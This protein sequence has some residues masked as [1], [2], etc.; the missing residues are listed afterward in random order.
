M[1]YDPDRCEEAAKGG[2]IFSAWLIC[3]V[4]ILMIVLVSKLES[5]TANTTE[6]GTVPTTIQVPS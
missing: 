6:M 5:E 3:A 4:V 1:E 2:D